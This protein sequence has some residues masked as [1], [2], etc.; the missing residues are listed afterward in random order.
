MY[1]FLKKHYFHLFH[2]VIACQALKKTVEGSASNQRKWRQ[3]GCWIWTIW[4]R[5]VV[6][7]IRLG[8]RCLSLMNIN[9]WGY[10]RKR[11]MPFETL[12][13]VCYQCHVYMKT[14]F[15]QVEEEWDAMIRVIHFHSSFLNL[16]CL[17]VYLTMGLVIDPYRHAEE[18]L[19][20]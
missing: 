12:T 9:T 3:L 16:P 8:P 1:E 20:T 5:D 10:A 18:Q 19:F 14:A 15:S 2:P 13:H 4:G 7:V 11:G 6:R 17:L